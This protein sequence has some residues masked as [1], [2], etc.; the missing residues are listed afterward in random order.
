MKLP[1]T[2][3]QLQ[4]IVS[5]A[6]SGDRAGALAAARQLSD[7]HVAAEAWRLLSEINA[8]SQRWEEALEDLEIALQHA[9]DSRPMRLARARLLERLGAD[10]A[11]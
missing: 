2:R 5:L 6:S 8:N 10:P 7:K 11:A 3:E 9:P 4:L 1:D